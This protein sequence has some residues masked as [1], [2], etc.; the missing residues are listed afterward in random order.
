MSL[1]SLAHFIT[2]TLF[3]FLNSTQH[4]STLYMLMDLVFVLIWVKIIVGW[5]LSIYSISLCFRPVKIIKTNCDAC[6]KPDHSSSITIRFLW[7][8]AAAYCWFAA[9]AS[10]AICVSNKRHGRFRSVWPNWAIYCS[11]GQLFKVYV[12]ICLV[13]IV[14]QFLKGSK[15]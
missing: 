14:G 13:Q 15:F 6:S 8:N 10:S 4:L 9:W 12:Y 5:T 7:Q 2:F 11:F 3:W 1:V